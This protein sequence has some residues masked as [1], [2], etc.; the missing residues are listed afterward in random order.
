MKTDKKPTCLD[1][2][3]F[4]NQ[5]GPYGYCKHYRHNLAQSQ[6]ICNEFNLKNDESD[7][8]SESIA[9]D[10][11]DKLD[12][13]AINKARR[14]QGISNEIHILGS[15]GA[16]IL[17]AIFLFVGIILGSEIYRFYSL[18]MTFKLTLSTCIL[19]FDILF[20]ILLAW[21]V[22]KS[23]ILS[24]VTLILAVCLVVIII[25]NYNSLWFDIHSIL[26]KLIN[27]LN[28]NVLKQ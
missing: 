28:Y 16:F 26:T 17:S 3:H 13:N 11:S 1:C 18:T 27:A 9:F 15:V 25:V 14:K 20:I 6:P 8:P 24:I 5:L 7:N 21:S 4:V 23:K 10:I 2:K 19:I 12:M 22:S